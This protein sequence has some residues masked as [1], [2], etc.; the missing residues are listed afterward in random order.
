MLKLR[1]L[2]PEV[3]C[4]RLGCEASNREVLICCQRLL[5]APA[6]LDF[7]GKRLLRMTARPDAE[8]CAALSLLPILPTVTVTATLDNP[9]PVAVD[10]ELKI[11]TTSALATAIATEPPRPGAKLVALTVEDALPWAKAVEIN[12]CAAKPETEAAPEEF[13]TA[14]ISFVTR[15]P[16]TALVAD[17]DDVA[18]LATNCNESPV[19]DAVPLDA[20]MLDATFAES[21]WAF[22]APLDAAIVPTVGLETTLVL[23]APAEAPT[24]AA[25]EAKTALA[26]LDPGDTAC[27]AKIAP[28]RAS[29]VPTAEDDPA[30]TAK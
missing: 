25:T 5:T 28:E 27:D 24:E 23:P 12:T 8:V 20:A 21:P 3:A 22:P 13:T 4:P 2:A 19:A 17:A 30:L 18:T 7:V 9:C 29:A 26:T 15:S 14:A 10:V 16:N 1:G 11:E 6:G